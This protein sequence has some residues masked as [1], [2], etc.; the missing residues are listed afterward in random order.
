MK[1]Y[2]FEFFANTYDPQWQDYEYYSRDICISHRQPLFSERECLIVVCKEE[3]LLTDENNTDIMTITF[4][5]QMLV[6][7][8][9]YVQFID[10]ENHDEYI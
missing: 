1:E 3:G 2:K 5:E 10:G 7:A 4:L 9:I 8:G 6:E